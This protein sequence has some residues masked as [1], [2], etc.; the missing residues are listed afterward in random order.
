MMDEYVHQGIYST[1]KLL[2]FIERLEGDVV[3]MQGYVISLIG[4][5]C[6]QGMYSQLFSF[7]CKGGIFMEG[8]V[9][10]EWEGP[11]GFY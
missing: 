3:S 9:F 10:Q 8:I 2:C 4:V 5:L 1:R 7:L 6:K 11:I